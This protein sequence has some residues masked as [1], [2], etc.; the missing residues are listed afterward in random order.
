M[1]IRFS[2]LFFSSIL[3]MDNPFDEVGRTF[4]K[5]VLFNPNVDKNTPMI[6]L[7][8]NLL[9]FTFLSNFLERGL[10]SPDDLR[11]IYREGFEVAI[12]EG[13]IEFILYS[14]KIEVLFREKTNG[15]FMKIYSDYFLTLIQYINTKIE[16][17]ILLKPLIL[18]GE[19]NEQTLK[20]GYYSSDD[21]STFIDKI[22]DNIVFESIKTK[23]GETLFSNW[24][25]LREYLT[26]YGLQDL[27][28]LVFLFTENTQFKFADRT[29]E[30]FTG[31]KEASRAYNKSYNIY[32]AKLKEKNVT[33]PRDKTERA[34][35][36][37]F[38]VDPNDEKRINVYQGSKSD[39]AIV[40]E[41]EGK[42][43]SIKVPL[44]D[45]AVSRIGF[46]SKTALSTEHYNLM[47]VFY[48]FSFVLREK[49]K[50]LEETE[51]LYSLV[52]FIL[53]VYIGPSWITN[54]VSEVG[55]YYL[56]KKFPPDKE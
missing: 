52:S 53:Y 15:D 7:K 3:A 4:Y 36:L 49:F 2:T 1:F 40:R 47:I 26:D 37:A 20:E 55:G 5:E 45:T 28:K 48:E 22:Q 41:T 29:E 38:Y 14:T 10:L 33:N 31:N 6:V 19:S 16:P 42:K 27:S 44:S 39:Y 51:V 18:E 56:Y 32:K 46:K 25:L 8:T 43:R 24:Q 35:A 54:F 13:A 21:L 50:Q 17:Q 11:S 23:V 34:I 12:E 9:C 30:I